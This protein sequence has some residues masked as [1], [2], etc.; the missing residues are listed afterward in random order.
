MDVEAWLIREFWAGR[1]AQWYAGGVTAACAALAAGEPRRAAGF[2]EPADGTDRTEPEVAAIR[3][4]AWMLD[5]C[6]WPGQT[7]TIPADPTGMPAGEA[8]AADSLLLVWLGQVLPQSISL[9]TLAT[10][11]RRAGAAQGSHM[12]HQLL[13]P[14]VASWRQL[15]EQAEDASVHPRVSAR[16]R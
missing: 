15:A 14:R 7:G 10:G 5:N 2:L 3:D 4:L 11:A 1:P 6:W 9:R 8:Y 13:L 16:R 12:A